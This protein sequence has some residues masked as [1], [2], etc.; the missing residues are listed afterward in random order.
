MEGEHAFLR[1]WDNAVE[2]GFAPG[3]Y[4]ALVSHPHLPLSVEARLYGEIHMMSHMCGASNRGDAR[5]I[6]EA[7]RARGEVA[8]RLT[9]QIADHDRRLKE[10]Q[11]D[12]VDLRARVRTL[13]PLAAECQELRGA[14]AREGLG[15]ELA[16]RV[17]ELDAAQ[18]ENARLRQ[19]VA[20]AQTRSDHLRSGLE[21]R[22]Q[23]WTR[24]L[25][26]WRGESTKE[27]ESAE[28][29]CDGETADLCGRCLLRRRQAADSLPVAPSRRATQRPP[30]AS[31]WGT[32]TIAGAARRTRASGGRS[33]LPG[34]LRQPWR[35]GF[36][37]EP[38]R[39]P[40]QADDAL[41]HG[42][43]HD[44]PARDRA[45]GPALKF[46]KR[47]C[48]PQGARSFACHDL[49]SGFARRIESQWIVRHAR[50]RRCNPRPH[51]GRLWAFKSS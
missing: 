31:R 19:A 39:Q 44:V 45:S 18:K 24:A 29:T 1:Y 43:R 49:R 20:S 30:A 11:A 35:D 27:S 15:A 2:A 16:A 10:A 17:R 12:I 51:S 5:A 46:Q 36:R 6:A 48:G 8:C 25:Q 21:A 47:S 33:V 23:Q 38:V 41:A 28:E 40:R 9:A 32:R 14:L 26:E 34:E 42:E 3:A 37:Q 50:R 13:E 4:W 22:T 7:Q